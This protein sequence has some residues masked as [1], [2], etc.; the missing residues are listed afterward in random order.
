ME[1]AHP[2]ALHGDRR[3]ISELWGQK[4]LRRLILPAPELQRGQGRK[5]AFL[6]L[7]SQFCS[8]QL[9]ILHPSFCPQHL[10]VE[11]DSRVT[12]AQGCGT[13]LK[14]VVVLVHPSLLLPPPLAKCLPVY[15]AMLRLCPGASAGS[16]LPAESLVN[17]LCH[18][19]PFHIPLPCLKQQQ[20]I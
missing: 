7:V 10:C 14:S 19:S 3:F 2:K 18:L 12:G 8:Q 4:E 11:R 6:L 1:D 13:M 5:P 16:W 17:R 20:T 15:P 9:S